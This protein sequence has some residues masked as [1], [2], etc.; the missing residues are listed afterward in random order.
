MTRDRNFKR[1][2]RKQ[3]AT[4]GVRYTKALADRRLVEDQ[5]LYYELRAPDYGGVS[6]SDRNGGGDR[7][8][9]RAAMMPEQLMAEIVDRLQPRGDVLE[10]ACG[11][12]GFTQLL[13]AKATSVTAVDASPSMLE[14]NRAAGGGERIIRVE[15]DLF[16][17]EPTTTFDF[18]F[19]STWLSHVPFTH[20]DSFWDLV[21]RC[22]RPDG[23]VA[24]VD[25]DDRATNLDD[26]RIV[27]GTPV[28]TR[29]LSDGRH[30][31]I[32]KVFWHPGELEERLRTLGWAITVERVGETYLLGS[33]A[34]TR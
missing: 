5:R 10:L 8:G 9:G 7:S 18:V 14:R 33:G 31:D 30:Y 1:D 12:G 24:F 21:R 19:F 3:A 23:R 34:L 16:T 20:F 6:H 26:L 4:S 28:A 11:P 2:V 27:D 25:E 29:T 17:W 32:V 15:A 22:L 13:A